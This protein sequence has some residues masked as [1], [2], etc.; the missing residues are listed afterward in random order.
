MTTS[1]LTTSAARA[2]GQPVLIAAS[3]P[4]SLRSIWRLIA[5]LPGEQIDP[6]DA[7]WA[8]PLPDRLALQIAAIALQSMVT[9]CVST[10]PGDEDAAIHGRTRKATREEIDWAKGVVVQFGG[11]LDCHPSYIE[12]AS[13]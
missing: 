8:T 9:G 2:A 10:A 1:S 3:I 13:K 12:E 6:D 11:L 7:K 4:P 5:R